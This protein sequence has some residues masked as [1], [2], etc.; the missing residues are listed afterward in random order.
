MHN[1]PQPGKWAISVWGGTDGTATD[2]AVASCT[3]GTV[4][5][6]Y[7]I[8]PQTQA[9]ER[10]FPGQPEI[11]SL[12]TLDHMQAIIAF[13]GEQAQAASSPR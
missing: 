13:G 6:A 7:W 8:D 10:W 11:S 2:Q 4:A 12:T 3:G 5:A 1:C 9:W